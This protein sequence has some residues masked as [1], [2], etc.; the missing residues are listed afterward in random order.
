MD[1]KKKI[2]FLVLVISTILIGI[3][4]VVISQVIQSNQAPTE[5][6]AFGFGMAVNK[7][8]FGAFEEKFTNVGCYGILS[9]PLVEGYAIEGI[10]ILKAYDLDIVNSFPKDKIPLSCTISLDETKSLDLEVHIYKVNSAIDPDENSLFSRI[11]SNLL[12][13]DYQGNLKTAYFFYGQ[14]LDNPSSCRMNFFNNRNDFEY[15]TVKVNG[16]EGNCKDQM[17]LAGELSY[18]LNKTVNLLIDQ[19]VLDLKDDSTRN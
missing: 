16:F 7:E 14:D 15:I 12:K 19:L 18:Y 8:Y 1:N 2:I 9:K 5:A 6:S 17:L 13:I 10:N 4:A 3:I 11:N